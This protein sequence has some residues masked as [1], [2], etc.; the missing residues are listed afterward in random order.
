MIYDTETLARK[1]RGYQTEEL[2]KSS[3]CMQATVEG[4]A[5]S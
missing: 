3:H 4:M 2:E 5:N 1:E